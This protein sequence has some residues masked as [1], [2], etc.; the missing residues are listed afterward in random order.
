MDFETD[1][2]VLILKVGW[3]AFHHGGLGIVRSLGR[4]GIPVYS[5]CEDRFVPVAVSKYLR[6]RYLWEA[7]ATAP[8]NVIHGL[9]SIGRQIGRPTILIPT[10]DF[11][12]ILI[13][14][15]AAFLEPYFIFPAQPPEL[16]RSL[17][18][19]AQLHLLCQRLGVACPNAW[20][21]ASANALDPFGDPQRFPVVVKR[22][23]AWRAKT[24]LGTTVVHDIHH[25][26]RLYQQADESETPLMIQEYIPRDVAQDWFFHGYFNARSECG[27]GFTGRKLRSFPPHAGPTTFAESI[28]NHTLRD[29][30]ERLAATLGFRGIMDLDFRFDARDGLYKLVDF[31]PRVGA[32]FRLFQDAARVDVVRALHLDMTGRPIRRTD[33]T[34]RRFVVE[35]YDA[36]AS[37]KYLLAGELTLRSWLRS[38]RS[39]DE[40]AWFARDDLAPFI[41][42]VFRFAGYAVRKAIGIGRRPPARHDPVF[43]PRFRLTSGPW[44]V[45]F[46]QAIAARAMTLFRRR[47]P[48]KTLQDRRT[49]PPPDA[50]A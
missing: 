14:E 47:S 15:R 34:R 37:A 22:P 43:S 44:Q 26:K 38:L 35:N 48:P 10:D 31:N 49:D 40:T 9:V 28:E 19:K 45:R 17:A 39:V 6:G 29:I 41:V 11:A 36:L 8:D 42:M 3:Y 12:A 16:P 24:A 25:L 13:A 4:L 30:A 20:F 23:Q 27:F 18:D 21:P 1:V 32:Q 7:S 2:P 33:A 46:P 5:T 50:V